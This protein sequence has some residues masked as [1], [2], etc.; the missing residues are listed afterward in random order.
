MP[1]Q[2]P[3]TP[4]PNEAIA[5]VLT[6][7][8]LLRSVCS[9]HRMFD[10]DYN[11]YVVW[12]TILVASLGRIFRAEDYDLSDPRLLG[13]NTVPGISRRAISRT[14]GIA[15]ETVRRK[16]DLLIEKGLVREG[17]GGGL[18]PRFEPGQPNFAGNIARTTV[19]L[20]RLAGELRRYARMDL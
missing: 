15:K 7:E 14:T 5:A 12:L 20:R 8:F 17:S 6:G 1:A 3:E 10:A 9:M 19:S 13:L 11:A 18:K 16:V 2:Q 4:A